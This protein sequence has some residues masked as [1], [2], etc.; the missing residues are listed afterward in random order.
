MWHVVFVFSS[1]SQSRNVAVLQRLVNFEGY[2]LDGESASSVPAEPVYQLHKLDSLEAEAKYTED[3]IMT[4]LTSRY[5]IKSVS[6]PR[7][8]LH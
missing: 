1:G 6:L 4:R 2:F 8:C 5:Q 3:R 7:C